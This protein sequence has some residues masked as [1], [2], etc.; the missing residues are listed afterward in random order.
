MIQKT[1]E[2]NNGKESDTKV[3]LKQ[4]MQKKHGDKKYL[5]KQSRKG[6]EKYT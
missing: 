2:P 4:S 6:G 3:S 1:I 5:Q